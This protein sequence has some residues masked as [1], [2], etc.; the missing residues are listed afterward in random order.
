VGVTYRPEEAIE[1]I[2]ILHCD[3][4]VWEVDQIRGAVGQHHGK[5]TARAFVFISLPSYKN[6]SE[7]KT[8]FSLMSLKVNC[9]REKVQMRCVGPVVSQLVVLF[10]CKSDFCDCLNVQQSPTLNTI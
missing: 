7:S 10:G 1:V 9:W 6:I 2:W 8:E 5:Q 4:R 3:C